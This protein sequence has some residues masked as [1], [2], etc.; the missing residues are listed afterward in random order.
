M[1]AQA[2]RVT[3][4]Q[5]GREAFPL[6]ETVALDTIGIVGLPNHAVRVHF[7]LLVALAHLDH[8]PFRQTVKRLFGRHETRSVQAVEMAVVCGPPYLLVLIF[9][10]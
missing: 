8:H 3:A 6:S 5:R 2:S 4:V 10:D 9:V 7:R 1:F